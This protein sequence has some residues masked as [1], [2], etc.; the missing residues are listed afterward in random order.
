MKNCYCLVV[1]SLSEG[2][3]RVILEAQALSKPVIAS[4][5]GGIPEI[6]K[7]GE[8][9]FLVNPGDADDLAEKLRI[10][11]SDKKL[12]IEMGKRG[13]EIIQ[14]KFSNEEYIKNYLDM[15]RF[16]N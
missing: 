2:L 11:L 9:G 1:P 6:I 3:P 12:A 7:D 16:T 13:R 8:N 15:I 14:E 10:L 4:R 5:V